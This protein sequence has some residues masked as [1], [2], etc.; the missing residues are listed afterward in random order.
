MTTRK[1]YGQLID[2]LD[3]PDLVDIQLSSYANFLQKDVP[4][5]TRDG[6][7]VRAG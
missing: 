2:V 6:R 4:A 7:G 3:I 1:N 5:D